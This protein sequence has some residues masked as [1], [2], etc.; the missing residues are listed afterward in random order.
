MKMDAYTINIIASIIR[1]FIFFFLLFVVLPRLLFGRGN[2]VGFP[3]NMLAGIILLSSFAIVMVYFLSLVRIYDSISLTFSFVVFAGIF[4]LTGERAKNDMILSKLSFH[5]LRIMEQNIVHWLR[6]KFKKKSRQSG[7]KQEECSIIWKVMLILVLLVSG[8]ERLY[9]A[10]QI[11]SPFSIEAYEN[12]EIVKALETKSLF[13]DQTFV[14]KGMHAIID[15]VYQFTR[16]NP[17]TL[18]HIFG[19][20][21]A[22]I[23]VG[24]MYLIVSRITGNRPAAL[25]AAAI[26]GMFPRILPLSLESQVEANSLLTSSIF[27][28]LSVYFLIEYI[29]KPSFYTFVVSSMGIIAATLINFF[30]I[31]IFWRLVPVFALAYFFSKR[32][33]RRTVLRRIFSGLV[34]LLFL[35]AFHFVNQKLNANPLAIATIKSI[36]TD[37]SFMRFAHEEMI[38]GR[39]VLFFGSIGLGILGLF[40]L[41]VMKKTESQLHYMVWGLATIVLAI[42]WFGDQ[43]GIDL[44]FNRTQ[45][46]FVLAVFVCINLGLVLYGLIFRLIENHVFEKEV[47][48]LRVTVI[49][50]IVVLILFEGLLFVNAP[51]IAKFRHMAEPDGYVRAIYEVEKNNDPYDWMVVS[52][53]GARTQVEGYGRFM[54]YLYFLKYY[55]PEKFNI[56]AAGVIPVKFLYIFTEKDSLNSRVD[57][58]FLPKINDLNKR[59]NLWCERFARKNQNIKIFYEDDQ[60]RIFQ[61]TVPRAKKTI[62]NQI[63]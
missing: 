27:I 58:A 44:D 42:F 35:V 1:I 10:F 60:V 50:L 48:P 30:A 28:I 40:F 33:G 5:G 19:A 31:V 12:L 56:Q 47:I 61:I 4:V 22:L 57:T 14:P 63:S 16:V 9:P 39:E 7:D 18:V 46:A 17:Q 54:D 8:F 52:H 25:I 59:L 29:K 21:S 43:F 55:S 6:E 13:Y 15:I 24:L 37:D 20:I 36:V 26:F 3:D 45:L 51:A 11:A 53:F 32:K 34:F 23:L 38:F 49:G 2:Q 62:S 41:A